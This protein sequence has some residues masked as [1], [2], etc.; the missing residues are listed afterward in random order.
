[1]NVTFKQLFQ[2]NGLQS[3]DE[4]GMLNIEDNEIEIES[5]DIKKNDVW[6]MGVTFF[7]LIEGRR[8][9]TK[10]KDEVYKDITSK[11]YKLPFK[12]CNSFYRDSNQSSSVLVDLGIDL[13]D[14]GATTV[15]LDADD[16]QQ[17]LRLVRQRPETVDQFGGQGF[18]ILGLFGVGK[19]TVEAQAH[20]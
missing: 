15:R 13:L 8:P 18:A 7:M 2:E 6:S 4:V 12:K 11:K 5:Y 19:T 16:L 20:V 3:F 1:M 10:S 14:T 17:L 9:W